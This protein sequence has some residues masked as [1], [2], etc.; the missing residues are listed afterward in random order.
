MAT[1]LLDP[2]AKN[3]A[4]A[5]ARSFF[6]DTTLPFERKLLKVFLHKLDHKPNKYQIQV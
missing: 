1:A 6:T 4:I 3:K 5:R 2:K